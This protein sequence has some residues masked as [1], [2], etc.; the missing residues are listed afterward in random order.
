[1]VGRVILDSTKLIVSKPGVEVST[2]TGSNLIFDS[3]SQK[4]LLT[5]ASG[6]VSPSAWSLASS[7]TGVA[8]YQNVFYYGKTFT[9]KPKVFL[10]F[11]SPFGGGGLTWYELNSLTTVTGYYRI[12]DT[13]GSSMVFGVDITTSYCVFKLT[14]GIGLF[15][16]GNNLY[17]NYYYLEPF[18]G[19]LFFMVVE[20][21]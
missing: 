10:M 18:P 12:Y 8:S 20:N 15:Y 3:R 14:Q 7:G 9:Y 17:G 11:T 2:A 19:N 5:Y 13:L 1:M 21:G 16:D 4:Y 6:Y